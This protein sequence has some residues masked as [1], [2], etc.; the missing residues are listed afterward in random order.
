[1]A[2]AQSIRNGNTAAEPTREELLDRIAELESNLNKKK[3]DKLSFHI[4]DKGGV[5]VYGLNARF[6]VTLYA[7][8]W[9]RLLMVQDELK[10]F[11][12]ANRAKLAQPKAA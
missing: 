12:H 11:I 7:D 9:E 1:M 3:A 10:Q 6:P 2:S 5:S 8:Q 4:G